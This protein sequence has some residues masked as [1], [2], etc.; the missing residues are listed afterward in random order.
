MKMKRILAAALAATMVMASALTASAA[1]TT[2]SGGSGSSSSSSVQVNK[3]SVSANVTVNVA[4]IKAKTTVAGV[5]A[6]KTIQGCAI[7]SDI[8][9]VRANLALKAGQ[10]PKIIVNDTDMKKSYLAMASVNAAAE[11]LG[12]TV[13][14]AINVDLGATQNGKWVELEDGMIVMMAGLPKNVDT[15]KTYAVVCVAPG[16]VISIFEDVDTIP[17]TVT[18]PVN[19][20]L[21]TYAIVAY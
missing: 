14:T 5:Y 15:A 13:I 2:V 9:D 11:A 7:L 18:F 20:G 10:T 21:G 19:A 3:N 17:T 6:A 8:A 1:T 4:G 16:G 12:A